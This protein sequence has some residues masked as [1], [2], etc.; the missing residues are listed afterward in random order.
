MKKT[1]LALLLIVAGFFFLPTVDTALMSGFSL[2]S[3]SVTS[4]AIVPT[5]VIKLTALAGLSLVVFN[6]ISVRRKLKPEGV[7]AERTSFES[8]AA[9]LKEK[10]EHGWR[11]GNPNYMS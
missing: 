10:V 6:L 7:F 2:G 3:D 9:A 5:S 4:A 8:I 11:H 1:F